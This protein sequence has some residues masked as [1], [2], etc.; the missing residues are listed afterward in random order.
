MSRPY[1][2][3]ISWTAPESHGEVECVVT[4]KFWPG[5]EGRTYGPPEDCYPPEAPEVQIVAVYEDDTN[6]RR[7]DLDEVAE[8]DGSL[9]DAIV[10]QMSDDG[11]PRW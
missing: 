11:D 8:D 6:V 1:T 3:T 2:D 10:E 4:F 5:S 7:P 9:Y